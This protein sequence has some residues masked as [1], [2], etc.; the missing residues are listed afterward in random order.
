MNKLTLHFV[1]VGHGDC[2]IV[3]FPSGRRMM[4]DVNNLKSLDEDTLMELLEYER[5]S[6]LNIAGALL[7]G[8]RLDQLERIAKYVSNLT[9]PIEYW[10]DNIGESE[11]FRFV[12]TH[13]DMD[14]LTGLHRIHEQEDVSILNFWDTRN[15]KELSDDSFEGSEYDVADWHT[16][17][18][19]RQSET[20][21]K[22]LML[23]R[24]NSGQYYTDDGIT[25]LAPT[26][27]LENFSNEK[28]EYNHI[29]Y[30]LMISFGDCR[31][32]LGGDATIDVWKDIYREYDEDFEKVHLLKASHHG[33][34][35]GYYQ[36]IVK[37]ME[38]THTIV[39]V[40]KKPKTDA[41]RKYSNYSS[42]YS[43]RFYG[44]IRAVCQTDGEVELY[45]EE[46]NC[47]NRD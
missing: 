22:T 16:Y 32:V 36:P 13:P 45:D 5:Y 35:S 41:S 26:T 11:I 42:V 21:P 17:Q 27:E 12:A 9:N 33:R 14:H 4:V 3:E 47:I 40:G 43:T 24:G 20:D 44:T 38:P 10:N 37:A 30:V 15:N 31:I 29:S 46:D 39:S 19:L 23:N 34:E 7:K 8:T 18:S 25:I 6:Q 2:T 1:N 28:E